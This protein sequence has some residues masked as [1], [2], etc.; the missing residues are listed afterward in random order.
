MMTVGVV[1]LGRMGEGVAY[2]LVQAG[3]DVIGSDPNSV[4]KEQIEQEGIRFMSLVDLAKSSQVI[5]LLVP[6]GQ[7]VDQVIAAIMPHAQKGVIIVDAGNSNFKDSQRRAQELALQGASFVDCGTSGGVHGR[8]DGFSLMVGGDKK[9]YDLIEPL[10]SALAV[11]EG[12]AYMGVSGAGHYVKM[13]HNGIE[14]AL[15]QAY[16][17]GFQLLKE[18]A[19]K[20]EDLDLAAITKVWTHGSVI[21]SWLLELSHDIFVE[22][23]KLDKISGR[24]Q[25]SGTGAWTV[26]EAHRQHIPVPLIEKAL[27]LRKESRETGGNY[28]SKIVALMRN[29]FGGHAF[30][31]K[32]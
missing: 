17:E 12:Y 22:D 21:R 30:E 18:G 15:M 9:T 29:K 31:I 23:Q 7:I 3:F 11:P 8:R 28:A 13:V 10:L 32:V 4:L 26:E 6:A 25:E 5:F 14:Y 24:V 20:D 1:G 16:A 2:R 19:F 27:L